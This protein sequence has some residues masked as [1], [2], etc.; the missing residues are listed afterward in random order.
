MTRIKAKICG[1]TTLDSLQAAID[2]GATFIGFVFFD[3]SPRNISLQQAELLAREIPDHVI[4]CGVFVNPNDDHLAATLDKIPLDLIQLHGT[5][6]PERVQEIK[7]RFRRPVMKAFAISDARDIT[8][9]K[10]Y[11]AVADMLLF[12][13]KAPPGMENALPGGNGLSF[14]WPLIRDHYWPVP[15]MLSGGLSSENVREALTQSGA[16]M[17][18]VSSGVEQAPGVK[19][20]DKITAFLKAIKSHKEVT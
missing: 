12:D 5:E 8:H 13:A 4:L 19:D 9:A 20:P 10:S 3:K 16:D 1:L 17:V 18:D 11:G 14:D 6:T 7:D 15:W 2:G